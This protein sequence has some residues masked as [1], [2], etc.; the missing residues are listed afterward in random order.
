MV[1]WSANVGSANAPV[2]FLSNVTLTGSS[3]GHELI[4]LFAATPYGALAQTAAP[5]IT[6][7]NWVASDQF[8]LVGY[9]QTDVNAANAAL[10]GGASSFKLSDGS[11]V[12]FIGAKPSSVITFTK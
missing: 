4:G 5:T 12:Q 2:N 8:A 11:T 9:G 7:A 6:V 10:A 1:L 3:A